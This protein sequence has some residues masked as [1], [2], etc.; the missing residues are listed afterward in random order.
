MRTP[1]DNWRKHWRRRLTI[2]AINPVT[3]E[4][5]FSA[6]KLVSGLEQGP[7][8]LGVLRLLQNLVSNPQSMANL[9]PDEA[10]QLSS[11]IGRMAINGD[12]DGSEGQFI[13]SLASGAVKTGPEAGDFQQGVN[14]L[15]NNPQF[16]ETFEKFQTERQEYQS[17]LEGAQRDGSISPQEAAALKS[18]AK[19]T[20]SAAEDMSETMMKIG[21][22][23]GQDGEGRTRG[24]RGGAKSWLQ[25]IAQALGR[26]G[27]QLAQELTSAANKI[28][29]GGNDPS[30]MADFQVKAMEFN[31]WMQTATNS[32]KALG[33][34]IT[35]PAQG[36]RHG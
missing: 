18:Q 34:G 27:D 8:E 12:I 2:M 29:S 33:D 25:A 1:V 5:L 10:L 15:W 22:D 17:M 26:I 23:Q 24:G 9:A 35:A 31:M 30:A 14:E 36:A 11:T 6:Y 20:A 3:L 19:E 4:A 28:G 32:L 21:M 16:R 7:S 13:D